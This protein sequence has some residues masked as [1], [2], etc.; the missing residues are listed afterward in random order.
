MDTLS[1]F[2]HPGPQLD[3]MVGVVQQE[4]AALQQLN[5]QLKQEI[6]KEKEKN[7]TLE[8]EVKTMME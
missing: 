6:E 7:R 8:I 3:R 1:Q 4:N 2:E 5:E